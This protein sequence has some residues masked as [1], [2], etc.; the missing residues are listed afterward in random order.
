MRMHFR[1]FPAFWLT[2]K[3]S[4]RIIFE[5]YSFAFCN[6]TIF[7]KTITTLTDCL[8]AKLQQFETPANRENTWSLFETILF[9]LQKNTRSIETN[10]KLRNPD[11]DIVRDQNLDRWEK[12]ETKIETS[13]NRSRDRD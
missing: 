7:K 8:E 3:Y 12:A 6:S 5:Q 1:L 4:T 9:N 10:F 11:H 13:K 2:L